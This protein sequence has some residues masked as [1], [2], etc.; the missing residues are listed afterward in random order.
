MF[1]CLSGCIPFL[2]QLAI[3]SYLVGISLHWNG[4]P[5]LS[6]LVGV[7]ASSF[8]VVFFIKVAMIDG[9]F[10]PDNKNL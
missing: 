5:I 9:L 4:G 3:M 10:F 6:I 8:P 1:I 2:C 7:R